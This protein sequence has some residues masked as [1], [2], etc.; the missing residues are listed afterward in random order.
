MN[1]ICSVR[2]RFRNR[3][4][5]RFSAPASA[6]QSEEGK[7]SPNKE[8]PIPWLPWQRRSRPSDRAVYRVGHGRAGNSSLHAKPE[9]GGAM[10]VH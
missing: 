5:N 6:S 1:H 9:L 4:I 3:V 8:Q 10:E 2:I 7:T